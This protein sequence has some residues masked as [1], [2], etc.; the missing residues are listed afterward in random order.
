M[1]SN[2]DLY[3]VPD[4]RA[5][6]LVRDAMDRTTTDLPP[7]PDLVAAARAQ[8]RRRR[9]RARFAIG[10]AVLTVAALGVAG[11]VALPLDK[12][13]PRAS[14]QVNVAAQPAASPSSPSA[15]SS[16]S[17]P[18]PPV[19]LEPSPGGG[20]M[21][22]LP[23]ALRAQQENF[24]NQAVPVLQNL[25]PATIG[26]VRRTDLSVNLYQGTKDG[27]TFTI[28]FSVRPSGPDTPAESPDCVTEKGQV[29]KRT[30]LP[31]GIEA[32]SATSPINNGNVS[33]TR[34][35]F[36]YGKSTVSLAISPHDES[37]TSAPV[38]NDQLLEVAKAS[39]FLDLVKAADANPVQKEQKTVPLG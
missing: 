14:G 23:P 5:V 2:E 12:S 29:C 1:G 34:L 18:L 35:H 28:I 8:G 11:T 7:L 24:Q 26:T 37:N 20:S 9:A 32:M 21:A 39:A 25:L 27:K 17:V 22:D 6:M 16:S 13:G 31:G 33:E 4:D 38:T 15:S 30:T 19:H 3:E 10:G 36:R